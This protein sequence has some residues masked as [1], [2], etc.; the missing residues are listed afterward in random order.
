[1]IMMRE[2]HLEVLDM[3]IDAM[4]G[5]VRLAILVLDPLVDPGH[6]V[7]SKFIKLINVN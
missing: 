3:T 2:A 7:E 4:T 6:K 1:M 5:V